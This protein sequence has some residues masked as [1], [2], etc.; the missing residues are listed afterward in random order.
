MGD[1]VGDT[2]ATVPPYHRH[3][4]D[5]REPVGPAWTWADASPWRAVLGRA[6][7]SAPG[8]ASPAPGSSPQ[9][10]VLLD[11]SSQSLSLGA[12]EPRPPALPSHL[13]PRRRYRP[14][15]DQFSSQFSSRSI[16]HPQPLATR[17][18]KYRGP[19]G[20]EIHCTCGNIRM[21]TPAHA[22]SSM[23]V[24][25]IVYVSCV[26]HDLRGRMCREM[27]ASLFF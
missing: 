5:G 27:L 10:A 1:G 16:T 13:V 20:Q 22:H 11:A 12:Q 24:C 2:E 14:L 8:A 9:P 7:S 18:I 26:C 23:R 21:G 6:A 25:A 19:G 4:Q 17:T 3:R 15:R